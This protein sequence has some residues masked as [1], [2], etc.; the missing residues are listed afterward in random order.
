L[1]HDGSLETYK[2]AIERK[3]PMVTEKWVR[4]SNLAEKM[5]DPSLFPPV[6]MERYIKVQE[7]SFIIPVSLF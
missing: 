4:Y 1:F 5:M 3:I 2:T 6:D 7:K